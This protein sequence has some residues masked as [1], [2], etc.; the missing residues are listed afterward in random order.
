MLHRLLHCD[1]LK[2]SAMARNSVSRRRHTYTK[3]L[4]ARKQ[5]IRHLYRRNSAY[6]ARMSIEDDQG[7]EKVA[8]VPLEVSTTAQVQ[9]ELRRTGG[10]QRTPRR[11]VPTFEEYYAKSYLTLLV[12]AGKRDG[13]VATEGGICSI[14]DPGSD[15]SASTRFVPA[16]FSCFRRSSQDVKAANLQRSPVCSQ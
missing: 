11:R 5:A 1:H 4:D 7:R 15:I 3:I 13:T 16:M 10:Q 9:E 12:S 6:Y 2:R 8:W 14:G